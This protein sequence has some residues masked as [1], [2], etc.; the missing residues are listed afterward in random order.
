MKVY[1]VSVTDPSYLVAEAFRC[2]RIVFACPTYNAGLFPKMETLL[3]ELAAH[4]LQ[5]RKVAV[6]ENGTWAS[7]AGKQ[8]KEILS[9]MKDME[10]YEETVTVE[11]VKTGRLQ[12]VLSVELLI[13]KY[14]SARR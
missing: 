6:L 7:T 5:K 4:N 2:D 13:V 12:D 8:M 11:A 3:H 10:I 1:D 9:G 14:S